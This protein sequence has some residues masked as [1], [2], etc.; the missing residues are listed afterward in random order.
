[1]KFDPSSYES[2]KSRKLRFYKDHPDG[3]IIVEAIH[4][5]L[6]YAVFKSLVYFN[7]EEQACGTPR[8][9]G[10]SLEYREKELKTNSYGKTYESVNYS[11]WT[12]NAEESAVGRAL[13]NAGYASNMKCSLEE[14]VKAKSHIDV[15]RE[16]PISEHTQN[17]SVDDLFIGAEN[18]AGGY[19]I[20][21]GKYKGQSLQEIDRDDLEKNY[22][23]WIKKQSEGASL[24][25][26][27]KEF[28]ASASE[29]LDRR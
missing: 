3:R 8:A 26:S 5:D 1:M 13:D 20:K 27:V 29:Y 14:I 18:A 23:W 19:I 16:H 9:T 7:K 15:A 28:I 10:H 21:F 24:S 2:V 25:L 22:N 4:V 17:D 11:S 12:E 6:D